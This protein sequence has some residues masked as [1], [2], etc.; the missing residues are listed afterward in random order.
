MGGDGSHYLIVTALHCTVL[1]CTVYQVALLALGSDSHCSLITAP[2]LLSYLQI[3]RKIKA[4]APE[5]PEIGPVLVSDLSSNDN[6]QRPFFRTLSKKIFPFNQVEHNRDSTVC[7]GM[8]TRRPLLFSA[9]L[10]SGS[11]GV[12]HGPRFKG[13]LL[14][15]AVLLWGVFLSQ[16][17]FSGGRIGCARRSGMMRTFARPNL[18]G[19]AIRRYCGTAVP[20]RCELVASS[21]CKARL[22]LIW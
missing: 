16:F 10:S 12:D 8:E 17:K 20:F 3:N 1:Y 21:P 9:F 4:S 13:P 15:F 6:L 11:A 7:G 18:S 2:S 5:A 14:A 22:G 19:T